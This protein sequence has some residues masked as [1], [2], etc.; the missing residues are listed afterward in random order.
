MKP[1][2][3]GSQSNFEVTF[4]SFANEKQKRI[5]VERGESKDNI[6]DE[7][8]AITVEDGRLSENNTIELANGNIIK[9]ENNAFK[10]VQ[11]NRKMK[12][13]TGA[14][15]NFEVAKTVKSK[16]GQERGA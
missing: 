16:K 3:E 2:I 10:T 15:L 11:R 14:V 4:I 7:S 13:K 6:F 1:T 5:K 9:F 8:K 12:A